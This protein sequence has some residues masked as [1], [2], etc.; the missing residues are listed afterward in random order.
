MVSINSTEKM[1]VEHVEEDIVN[2]ENAAEYLTSEHKN[3]FLQ[4]IKVE[5]NFI[6]SK[7]SN[8][9]FVTLG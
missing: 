7:L 1:I 6:K 8:T 5:K 2:D 4:F 3:I 9:L